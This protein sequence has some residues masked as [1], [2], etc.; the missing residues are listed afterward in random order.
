[1]NNQYSKFDLRNPMVSLT[2]VQ[3]QL[4]EPNPFATRARKGVRCNKMASGTSRFVPP[5]QFC[6][7]HL[8]KLSVELFYR[9]KT[10]ELMNKYE[11]KSAKLRELIAKAPHFKSEMSTEIVSGLYGLEEMDELI[12]SIEFE[13]S[14]SDLEQYQREVKRRGRNNSL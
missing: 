2:S 1:M 5:Y 4:E 3:C 14:H 7:A 6:P 10:K 12:S 13:L 8:A 9:S 11:E